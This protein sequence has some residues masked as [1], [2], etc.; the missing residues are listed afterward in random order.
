MNFRIFMCSIL[1]LLVCNY[2]KTHLDPAHV[3]RL[4]LVWKMLASKHHTQDFPTIWHP[5][6]DRSNYKCTGNSLPLA[7]AFVKAI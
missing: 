6:A 2:K 3:L 7:I 4:K 1:L 5:K